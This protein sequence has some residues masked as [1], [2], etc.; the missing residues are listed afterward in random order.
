VNGEIIQEWA[1]RIHRRKK[2]IKSKQSESTLLREEGR[3]A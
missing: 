2:F 1:Q 3:Q